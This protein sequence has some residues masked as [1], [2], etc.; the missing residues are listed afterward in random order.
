[1]PLTYIAPSLNAKSFTCPHCGVVARFV[2]WAY[3]ADEPSGSVT[4]EQITAPLMQLRIARCEN[5]RGNCIWLGDAL[6]YP[7]R[8]SAP[9][10]NPDMPEDVRQDYEEASRISQKSPRG[11]AAL[12]RLAIQKLMVHLG[13]TGENIN[14]DIKALVAKGLPPTIQQAL[15]V[16]RVTGNNAVHPG[17]L[18]A[19]DVHVAER[20][21]PLVN[22]IVESQVSVPKQIAELYGGLPEG[23]RTAIDRRDA[24]T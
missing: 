21:F 23:A 12:V 14:A 10:P 1:M 16:V 3:R 7:D 5:C 4:E 20:L 18:D 13:Q 2:K 8:G 9:M 19:N 15:D 22:V 17:V 11:A 6:I 24:K